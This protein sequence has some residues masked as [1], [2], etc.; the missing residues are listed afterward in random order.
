LRGFLLLTLSELHERDA[1]RDI[2]LFLNMIIQSSCQE[3]RGNTKQK[4]L[5]NYIDDLVFALYLNVPLKS[6]G[7]NKA[8]EIGVKILN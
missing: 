3:H 8:K 2:P 6:I 4:Q 1:Y 7:L 5:K